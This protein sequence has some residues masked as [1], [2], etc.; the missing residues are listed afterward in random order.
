ML[1][2]CC[3]CSLIAERAAKDTKIQATKYPL[4]DSQNIAH[5][6]LKVGFMELIPYPTGSHS[7]S[8]PILKWSNRHCRPKILH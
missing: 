1:S 4:P 2:D 6:L 8:N 5:I 7:Q 3:G